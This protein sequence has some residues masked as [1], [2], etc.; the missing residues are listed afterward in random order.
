[1]KT[2][3]KPKFKVGDIIHASEPNIHKAD[4]YFEE[5]CIIT[6]IKAVIYCNTSR[7][8]G[9]YDKVNIS[10]VHLYP[11]EQFGNWIVYFEKL[12]GGELMLY[13]KFTY[14]S[15]H[16]IFVKLSVIENRKKIIKILLNE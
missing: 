9:L 11:I 4:E 16:E 15:C 2:I 7:V 6:D 3:T 8:L 14:N 10:D 12:L 5:L 13:D 1:M